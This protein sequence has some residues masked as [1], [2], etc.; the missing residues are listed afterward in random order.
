M[1]REFEVTREVDLPAAPDDVWTAITAD[2]AA[3]SSRPGWRS[4]P[5]PRRPRGRRSRPG[6]RRTAS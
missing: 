4:P 1:S 6:T 5:A 3:W 2:T